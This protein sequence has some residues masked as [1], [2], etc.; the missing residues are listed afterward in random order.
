MMNDETSWQAVTRRTRDAD[1][2]F[3]YAVATTGIYCRPSCPSKRP[4]RC[5]VTFFPR[6]E[7][8]ERAGYR[9]CRRC[10]PGDPPSSD[11]SAAKLRRACAMIDR[12]L[13]D[14]DAAPSL[15]ALGESLATSPFHLQRLFKRHLGISPR[16]YGDARKLRR[17]KEALASG[18]DVTSALYAAGYGS[19]SR[20]YERAKAQLGMTPAS[21]GRGGAG[22]AIGFAT[23]PTPLGRLLVAATD[24]GICAV[25]LGANDKTL[26]AGLRREYPAATIARDSVA[27][28]PWL[29]ALVRHLRGEKPDLALPLDLVATG[30]Q[31]RVWREL[32]RIP[33]G[34]T[35]TYAEIAQRIGASPRGARAVARACAGNRLALV[36]PCHRVVRQDGA[37]AGY[38]W[39]IRRKAK[40]LAREKRQA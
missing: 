1:G 40:L 14:G 26:E 27:L 18:S 38:R 19:A 34:E 35:A 24:K 2:S 15:S 4:L 7:L 33:Y 16:D 20:L 22:A 17:V 36:I 30:F 29:A 39:G 25:S 31:W 37:L 13:D 23:V 12:A 11:P 32:Q 9:P 6:P 5:N 10:R 3:V 28:G 8:A 21:Y